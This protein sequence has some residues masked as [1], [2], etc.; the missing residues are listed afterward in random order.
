MAKRTPESPRPSSSATSRGTVAVLPAV[1]DTTFALHRAGEAFRRLK[2]GLRVYE[3]FEARHLDWYL[4]GEPSAEAR[5]Y[6]RSSSPEVSHWNNEVENE[7]HRDVRLDY[8]AYLVV[9][10]TPAGTLEV[11]EERVSAQSFAAPV[12]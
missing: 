4:G 8:Q 5:G 2:S 1:V 12:S 10:R 7:R 9:R 11:R 3:P 6:A